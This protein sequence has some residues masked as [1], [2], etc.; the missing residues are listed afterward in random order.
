MSIED[1]SSNQKDSPSWAITAESTGKTKRYLLNESC[2]PPTEG[3]KF[4]DYLVWVSRVPG[5][6]CALFE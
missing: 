2:L 4:V 5:Q 3:P 1:L 6:G